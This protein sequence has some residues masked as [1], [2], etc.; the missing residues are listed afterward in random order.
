MSNT[1]RTHASALTI[2][3]RSP[4]SPDIWDIFGEAAHDAL[5]FE[6]PS[7]EGAIYAG[8]AK[9]TDVVYGDLASGITIMTNA[10]TNFADTFKR[11]FFAPGN[12]FAKRQ[13][14]AAGAITPDMT[15]S[16]WISTLAKE[17]KF[18]DQIDQTTGEGPS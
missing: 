18:N 2:G 10:V 6:R 15:T 1:L 12:A 8:A 5:T 13:D 17:G 7:A 11:L 4:L 3:R 9:P 16:P 14:N